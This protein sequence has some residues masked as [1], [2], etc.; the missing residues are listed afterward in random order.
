MET[1]KN[2]DEIDKNMA[3]VKL[4]LPKGTKDYLPEEKIIKQEILDTLRKIFEKYGYNPLE[5]PTLEYLDTLNN[6]SAGGSEIGKQIFKLTDRAG[7]KLGLRFDFTVPLARV[8]SSY[9]IPKPFKRYQIGRVFREEFGTRNREFYQCDVDVIGSSSMLADA[10]VLAIVQ[11]VFDKLKLPIVIKVNNRKLLAGLMEFAGIPANKR[12]DASRSLDKLDKLNR[13][14]LIKDAIENGVSE[15]SIL[16]VLDAADFQ[17][18]N[19]EILERLKKIITSEVGKQG[20]KEM[21]ELIKF[22]KSFGVK[23]LKFVPSLARGL[24][25]YT[26]P[27]FEIFLKDRPNKLSVTAGGRF[28]N[29][30]GQFA[31]KKEQI[32]ATGLSFGLTRIYDALLE[33]K[34]I[35]KKKSV[36]QVFVIPIKGCEEQAIQIAQKLRKQG[37]NTDIDLMSRN[38]RKNLAYAN[39]QEIPY[40]LIIGRKEIQAKKYTLRN[41]QTGKEQKLK[42][43]DIAKKIL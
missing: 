5:T 32:P 15:D 4:E 30:I 35:R 38:P 31:G 23:D 34:L 1:N 42:L 2:N 26:G 28:D 11:E 29:M 14:E 40:T 21:E 24:D 27:V 10:E 13:N 12:I 6:K 36:V 8:F 20:I 33:K 17:G 18:T 19:E 43:E 16:R 25:Y 3:K 22:T 39:K 9:Q 7:R 37:I 41:M